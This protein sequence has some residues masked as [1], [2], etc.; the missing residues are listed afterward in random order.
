MVRREMTVS[1]RIWLKLPVCLSPI[2][3]KN[4]ELEFKGLFKTSL[5]DPDIY[6][7]VRNTIDIPEWSRDYRQCMG[8]CTPVHKDKKKLKEVE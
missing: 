2:E 8:G 5:H 1:P 7:S 3:K 4:L 6:Y